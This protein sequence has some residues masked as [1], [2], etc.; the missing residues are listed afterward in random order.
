MIIE[1]FLLVIFIRKAKIDE[2]PQVFN[3][4]LGQMTIVGPRPEDV[5]NVRNLYHG[6][7]KRILMLNQG[8][9]VLLVFMIILMESNMKMKI[10]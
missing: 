5:A 1:Y 3:I 10:I 4:L 8:L 6:E 7:Y 9:L 2:M